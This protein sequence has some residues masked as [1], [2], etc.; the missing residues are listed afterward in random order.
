MQRKKSICQKSKSK[1]KTTLQK[2]K[3]CIFCALNN[4]PIMLQKSL[5]QKYSKKHFSD[6]SI[7]DACIQS[8]KFVKP[9]V[10]K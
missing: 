8:K 10:E 7:I 9:E 6:L 5:F 3:D 1:S 2:K 4:D